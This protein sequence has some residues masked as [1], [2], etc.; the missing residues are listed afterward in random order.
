MHVI[1]WP[2]IMTMQE[3]ALYAI[4]LVRHAQIVV[5]QIATLVMLQKIE[6]YQ[7]PLLTHVL[8]IMVSL[9]MAPI[10]NAKLVTILV[11]HV[12]E[13]PMLIVKLVLLLELI[14]KLH[15][16]QVN[17]HVLQDIQ[18]TGLQHALS[19]LVTILVLLVTAQPLQIV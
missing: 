13:L 17:V 4:I 15:L 18:T 3:P 16:Q 6:L 1:V 11:R 9:M 10:L 8:A 12:L 2:D 14:E 7:E 19:L 5:L